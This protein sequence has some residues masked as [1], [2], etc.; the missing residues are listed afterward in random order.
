MAEPKILTVWDQKNGREIE[1]K[2][3]G[4]GFIRLV[5]E[6][7]IGR[8][9]GPIV[10]GGPFISKL[11]GWLQD[12]WFSRFKVPG[13]VR[14]FE[15]PMEEYEPGPFSN[16]Q[17]FFIRRFKEGQRPFEASPAAFP[18]FCEGRYLAF[19]QS[20]SDLKLH[21]KGA[22]LSPIEIIGDEILGNEMLGGPCAVARLCPVDYH[23]FHF[24]DTG[25]IEK[26]YRIPGAYHSV[27][28]LALDQYPRVFMINEREVTVLRT[29]NFGR[30]VLVDVG[31]ICVGKIV[32]SKGAG[33]SFERGEE[34][35]YFLFGG[36]TTIVFGSPGA[37]TWE[38]GLSTRSAE[39]I[40]TLVRLGEK[41][42]SSSSS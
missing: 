34:K 6:K 24:P 2:I 9:L 29:E 13:F 19:N 26:Q 33:E 32:Q 20:S 41:L 21:V 28:P 3:Y 39:G 37:W 22:H 15:I 16:F 4:D 40:E 8:W 14:R 23:R 17:E 31:A 42:G 27:N 25:E 35:G 38:E 30:V 10:S 7:P 11:Y 5:Y 18:A 12:R 1:E 36:S